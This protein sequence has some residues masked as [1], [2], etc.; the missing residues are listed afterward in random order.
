[1]EVV[2]TITQQKNLLVSQ[3]DND[4]YNNITESGNISAYKAETDLKPVQ[5]AEIVQE[6]TEIVQEADTIQELDSPIQASEPSLQ[7]SKPSVQKP[8]SSLQDSGQ[9]VQKPEPPIRESEPIGQE[10]DPIVQ[11]PVREPIV[12][13][14]SPK[15]KLAS[16]GVFSPEKRVRIDSTTTPTQAAT[17]P[18]PTMEAYR[19]S[20]WTITEIQN[21]LKNNGVTSVDNINF[22]IKL[23]AVLT[24]SSYGDNPSEFLGTGY[25]VHTIL[26]FLHQD[27]EDNR[28]HVSLV[29]YIS[30]EAAFEVLL[31]NT[32]R[33]YDHLIINKPR[34]LASFAAKGSHIDDAEM[35]EDARLDAIGLVKAQE[36]EKVRADERKAIR[37]AARPFPDTPLSDTELA[38][39][40]DILR[41]EEILVQM[42]ASALLA[43]YQNFVD[44]LP[45]S[46]IIRPLVD[47][48][49]QKRRGPKDP[50][51]QDIIHRS[52]VIKSIMVLESSHRLKITNVRLIFSSVRKARFAKL[53]LHFALHYIL[54]TYRKIL[55]VCQHNSPAA[56]SY[57][58]SNWKFYHFSLQDEIFTPKY[59]G[60][61]YLCM[62]G[63]IPPEPPV[64][65]GDRGV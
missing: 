51:L 35:A 53:Q 16:S 39:E 7:D 4:K 20:L 31:Q 21:G 61:L 48:A 9:P 24:C 38:A 1:M 19:Y 56:L 13:K 36:R 6:T 33:L 63:E 12:R 8:E 18:P 28:D 22:C 41:Q 42:E 62:R 32:I 43:D 17:P 30:K 10:P 2:E 23:F 46:E 3:S 44:L 57:A 29:A 5:E 37:M 64:E 11:E 15:K 26:S 27:C 14:R 45:S 40:A 52:S 49:F 60:R 59:D 58:L 54:P 55:F 65:S 34:T 25:T 50:N 47:W